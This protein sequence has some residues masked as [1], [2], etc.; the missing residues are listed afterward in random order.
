MRYTAASSG[1][2]VNDR[3]SEARAPADG[4]SRDF[5]ELSDKQATYIGVRKDG[6]YKPDSYRY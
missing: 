6:P 3:R 2:V 5:V 1:T 4:A